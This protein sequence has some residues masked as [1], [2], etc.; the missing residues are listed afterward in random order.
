GSVQT[1]SIRRDYRRSPE[2]GQ[3][4]RVWKL[5]RVPAAAGAEHAHDLSGYAIPPGSSAL[6]PRLPDE[7]SSQL[8][9]PRGVRP[10]SES[11]AGHAAVCQSVL[12]GAQ[13]YGG[14]QRRGIANWN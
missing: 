1:A 8:P 4:V 10:R 3:A 14:A 5:R 12:A 7:Y 2:E 13:Y 6:L 9:G 11:E